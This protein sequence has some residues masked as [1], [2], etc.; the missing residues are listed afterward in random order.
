MF[1]FLASA[2]VPVPTALKAGV[3]RSGALHLC[4]VSG[5]GPFDALGLEDVIIHGAG[6]GS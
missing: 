1:Q 2:S 6:P 5:R 4:W 3:M